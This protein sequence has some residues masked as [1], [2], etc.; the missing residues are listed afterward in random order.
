MMDEAPVQDSRSKLSWIV[1]GDLVHGRDE[2]KQNL[3]C[4]VESVGPNRIEARQI[5]TQEPVVFDIG[6]GENIAVPS[7]RLDSIMPLPVEVHDILLGLDR[8][9]RLGNQQISEAEKAI[10]DYADQVYLAH[11]LGTTGR[12]G[13]KRT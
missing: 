5:T 6:T 7:C 2:G 8:K 9:M 10:L 3:I 4:L 13:R 11:P 1:P 12:K